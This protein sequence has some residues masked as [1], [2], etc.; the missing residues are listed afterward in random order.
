MFI[1]TVFLSTFFEYLYYSIIPDYKIWD[2]V[3]S[4]IIEPIFF[5]KIK[6]MRVIDWKFINEGIDNKFDKYKFRQKIKNELDSAN[7]TEVEQVL[8]PITN[9]IFELHDNPLIYP[10]ERLAKFVYEILPKNPDLA[11]YSDG[12]CHFHPTES[13]DLSE[14]DYTNLKEI[15]KIMG[16]YE[17]KFFI[18]L[19]IA[20]GNLENYIKKTKKTKSLFVSY[21]MDNIKNMS[22]SARIFYTVKNDKSIGVSII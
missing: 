8:R 3:N 6:N 9:D 14:K 18:S 16:N 2:E 5:L 17:K 22:F 13:A 15:S 4:I 21:M 11:N 7:L 10:Y 12:I 20:F 1:P 19:V